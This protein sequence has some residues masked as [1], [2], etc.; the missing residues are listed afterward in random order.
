MSNEYK[1]INTSQKDNFKK[2]LVSSHQLEN[3]LNNF[4]TGHEKSSSSSGPSTTT[5]AQPHHNFRFSSPMKKLK[6]LR[7]KSSAATSTISVKRSPLG[8]H[9]ASPDKITDLSDNMLFG[10]RSTD[11][12]SN[13]VPS[14]IP[15]RTT[16]LSAFSNDSGYN[17]L[18]NTHSSNPL[19]STEKPKKRDISYHENLR[20]DTTTP[21]N[22]YTDN[23][24]RN[25]SAV[26]SSFDLNNTPAQNN[27]SHG[28]NM[29]DPPSFTP[30]K[31]RQQSS[32][33]TT[34]RFNLMR[35]CICEETVKEKTSEE[36]ILTLECGH[37][38]H[39]SCIYL[40]MLME[41]EKNHHLKNEMLFPLCELCND[42]ITKCIPENEASKDKLYFKVLIADDE[43]E[44][45]T[46]VE[47][48][49]EVVSSIDPEKEKTMQLLS[50][51]ID[52]LD[53]LPVPD[54]AV[55]DPAEIKK[56]AEAE[57]SHMTPPN[58]IISVFPDNDF[59][60]MSPELGSITPEI[61]NTTPPNVNRSEV[62]VTPGGLKRQSILKQNLNSYKM[63]NG[64]PN[65][66]RF[67]RNRTSILHQSSISRT[68]TL[69]KKHMSINSP[70]PIVKKLNSALPTAAIFSSINTSVNSKPKNKP[71]SMNLQ[72]SLNEDS[73]SDDELMIVQIEGDHHIEPKRSFLKK[74]SHSNSNDLQKLK[75]WGKFN[76]SVSTQTSENLINVVKDRLT[77]VHQLIEK[78]SDQLNKKN[79]DSDLGLLRI[80]N[81]FE[82]CKVLDNKAKDS[83]YLC[84]CY[85]FEKMLI[86]DFFDKRK[87]GEFQMIKITSESINVDAVNEH[88][89]R[90]SC[91]TSTD[92]NIFQFRSLDKKDSKVLEKWIS[93]LL[94]FELEFYDQ[95]FPIDDDSKNRRSSIGTIDENEGTAD[96][97]LFQDF[98]IKKSN[99]E[100]STTVPIKSYDEVE[101]LILI[102]QLDS[103][104]KIKIS[105]NLNLVNSI[106]SLNEYF[107][108]K[109]KTLKFVIV[110][111]KSKILC[112]G[113]SKDVLNQL[114]GRM[115]FDQI[116][117]KKLSESSWST[118]VLQKYFMNTEDS[119][120][121]V[122]VMSNT[123]MD[124]EQ[125]CLFNDFYT[126]SLENVLKI[127]VGFLNVD[128]SEEINDLVEINS[129]LDMMEILCFSLN[130]EF[131]QDDLTY[132][133]KEEVVEV[134]PKEAEQQNCNSNIS[135]VYT[136]I[137]PLTPLDFEKEASLNSLRQPIIGN[138]ESD[139]LF[140]TEA[141]HNYL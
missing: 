102:L 14:D 42:G 133:D 27:F 75:N 123:E 132:D 121:N 2:H 45:I 56:N 54:F 115:K 78:H 119:E 24:S 141:L 120:L 125:N 108:K 129:W 6:N 86:L 109:K 105:E 49:K 28:L 137:T 8:P 124:F 17:S 131:G 58:Q 71:K 127:H 104:K 48:P 92:I 130:L 70:K 10:L 67:G 136:E 37:V 111:Q 79:I 39:D 20:V 60:G 66:N 65:V 61:Y 100:V 13:K 138:N 116:R 140:D 73:D 36:K 19:R 89:F 40:H 15:I 113:S 69:S 43:S 16:S 83:F 63:T 95:P 72:A 91:L 57:E 47:D 11:G 62:R 118:S 128:Y 51:N 68:S 29:N 126:T 12:H 98:I 107:L 74:H 44:D 34:K 135:S 99:N 59:S 1:R 5:S 38:C 9:T 35:C 26:S 110:D 41:K 96:N 101:D 80:S 23:S 117:G 82:V 134:Q 4:L 94:N 55:Q 33:R 31:L 3:N 93:A 30:P 88:V 114:N 32:S 106:K 52:Y 112:I 7:N 53:G 85:L 97:S 50:K 21:V 76:D 103:E 77:L 84:K 22:K 122:V 81:V 64:S 18:Y 25:V 90:V 139:S 87:E 46:K